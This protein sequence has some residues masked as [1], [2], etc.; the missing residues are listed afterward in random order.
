MTTSRSTWTI[1]LIL[2]LS[3]VASYGDC[4][5]H[6]IQGGA[7]QKQNSSELCNDSFQAAAA[8]VEG[9]SAKTFISK[10]DMDTGVA[11]DLANKPKCDSAGSVYYMVR[12]MNGRDSS[13]ALWQSGKAGTLNFTPSRIRLNTFAALPGA[14]YLVGINGN[15]DHAAERFDAT[16]RLVAEVRLQ[17]PE[18]VD[19]TQSAAFFSGNLLVAGVAGSKPY[20]ALLGPSGQVIKE[21]AIDGEADFTDAVTAADGNAYALR[22][23]GSVL[24]ISPRGELIRSL[25][26]PVP[27]TGMTAKGLS[28]SKSNMA[29]SFTSGNSTL[30]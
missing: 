17:I 6:P 21:I 3:A 9:L 28:L 8:E 19:L 5:Q 2:L 24:V 30:G 23:L 26:L 13:Y 1:F 4:D 29:V 15:G 16:G 10:M 25:E 12:T 27:Q 22:S 18:A 11:G 20:L 14:V 7:F